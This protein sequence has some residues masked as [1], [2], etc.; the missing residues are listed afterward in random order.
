MDRAL[1]PTSPLTPTWQVEFY[2]FYENRSKH[3]RSFCGQLEELQLELGAKAQ[4]SSLTTPTLTLRST[5]RPSQSSIT[6]VRPASRIQDPRTG[7][8][9][10]R[11]RRTIRRIGLDDQTRQAP[12][13]RHEMDR[14]PRRST[15]IASSITSPSRWTKGANSLRAAQRQL[16]RPRQRLLRL[17][18]G[19][20]CRSSSRVCQEEVFGP[21]VTVSPFRDEAQA[22]EIANS[23]EYGLGAG[24][25]TRDLSRA[26]RVAANLRSGMVWIIATSEYTGIPLWWVGQSGYG[27]EMGFDAMHEYTEAKSVW[28]NVSAAIPPWYPVKLSHRALEDHVVERLSLRRARGTGRIRNRKR[29]RLQTKFD[30]LEDRDTAHRRPTRRRT[31][32]RI[33]RSVG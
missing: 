21:F 9:L 22:L 20:A 30:V 17:A 8:H 7:Q 29:R 16:I 12:G 33:P 13:H 27:R 23:T 26:H 6:K 2:G 28:L 31:T 25:W 11:V 14:S 18:D 15:E 5:D 10:R 1:A 19:R 24:L 4:I 3:R 32:R